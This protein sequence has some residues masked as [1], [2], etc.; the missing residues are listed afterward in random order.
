MKAAMRGRGSRRKTPSLKFFATPN[1]KIR[2]LMPRHSKNRL[3]PQNEIGFEFLELQRAKSAPQSPFH[4]D[5]QSNYEV[6]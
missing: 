6:C 1:K 5:A 2:N 3:Y 4:P